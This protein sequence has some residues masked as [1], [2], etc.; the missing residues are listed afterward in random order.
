MKVFSDALQNTDE[1]TLVSLLHGGDVAR[2]TATIPHPYTSA[3]A[4]A[5]LARVASNGES[6]LA[7]R[8][9]EIQQCAHTLVGVVSALPYR[10]GWRNV[11]YWIGEPYRGLGICSLALG[12]LMRTTGAPRYT[13]MCL[14]GNAASAR[15]L[16]RNGFQLAGLVNRPW[17][18]AGLVTLQAYVY[19]PA[20]LA[21]ARAEW[22]DLQMP[23]NRPG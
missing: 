23:M 5:W 6:H 9:P 17:R 13:G 8:C 14:I 7:I 20:S 16:V 22:P 4:Q 11:A 15:V 2:T 12:A 18:D 19:P 3:H 10:D 21:S 1:P